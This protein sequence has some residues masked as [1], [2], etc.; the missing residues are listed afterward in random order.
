MCHGAHEPRQCR[1]EEEDRSDQTFG[2]CGDG[3]RGPAHVE[4][5]GPSV[6]QPKQKTVQGESNE[7]RQ[8]RFRNI[9][10]G[11]EKDADTGQQG[12]RRVECRPFVECAP[13]PVPCKHGRRQ[14]PESHGK[15]GGEHVI[16]E[17][18]IIDG[19]EPVG[20]GRLLQIADAID[21]QR[22]PIAG[23]RHVLSGIGMRGIGIVK[24]GWREKRREIDGEPDQQQNGPGARGG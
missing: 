24:Q 20:K 1:R 17:G 9:D 7:E 6:V 22:H 12:K 13:R 3:E 18:M 15:M 23:E 16:A 11:K 19:G 8:Q 14:N 4:E 5:C 10:P 21:L 2:Q